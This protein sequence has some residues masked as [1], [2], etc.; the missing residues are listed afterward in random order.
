MLDRITTDLAMAGVT[1]QG[2]KLIE[3]APGVARAQVQAKTGGP[4]IPSRS[5]P[6]RM[7]RLS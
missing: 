4:R 1:P 7:I 2:L 3:V 6:W 5:P